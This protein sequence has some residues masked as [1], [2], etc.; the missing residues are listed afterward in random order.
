MYRVW[1]RPPL[2]LL[3]IAVPTTTRTTIAKATI[4]RTGTLRFTS[5]IVGYSDWHGHY[6]SPGPL[7]ELLNHLK[8]NA[9]SAQ[10]QVLLKK[11]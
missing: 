5:R 6:P 2:K 8:P 3:R 9:A 1:P 4:T 7:L 11:P 10:A